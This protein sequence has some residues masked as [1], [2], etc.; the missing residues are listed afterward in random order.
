MAIDHHLH[1]TKLT[2]LSSYS[3]FIS[4]FLIFRRV[5]H[6]KWLTMKKKLIFRKL[7]NHAELMAFIVLNMGKSKYF[8]QKKGF[9]H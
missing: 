7:I 9:T 5:D 2:S 6:I 1:S 4:F 3:F 8:I